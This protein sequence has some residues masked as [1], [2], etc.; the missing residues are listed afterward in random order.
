M[1]LAV[2]HAHF[3]LPP[4]PVQG[5]TTASS[6]IRVSRSNGQL[7]TH[8]SHLGTHLDGEIHFFTPGRDIA[9]LP[10]NDFLIG[11][12]VVVD[13][14]DATGDHQVYTPLVDGES[15]IGPAWPWSRTPGTSC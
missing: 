10:L 12:G 8:S 15:C 13:L 5:E 7:L 1:P 3:T 6:T 9:S 11:P 14:S 4:A 2:M